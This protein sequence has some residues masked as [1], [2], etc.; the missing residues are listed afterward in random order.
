MILLGEKNGKTAMALTVGTP[1]GFASY[2]FIYLFYIYI[3]IF[4]ILN[5]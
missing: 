4:F 1:T 5:F 2:F 3:Y